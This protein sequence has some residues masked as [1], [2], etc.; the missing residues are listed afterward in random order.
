[1]RIRFENIRYLHMLCSDLS[2]VR[3]WEVER[4]RG[5]WILGG[6]TAVIIGT[7]EGLIIINLSCLFIT[8]MGTQNLF[9]SASSACIYKFM[10][11][12][13][14]TSPKA[15]FF[16]AVFV[17]FCTAAWLS[18]HF[19]TQAASY[20]MLHFNVYSHPSAVRRRVSTDVVMNCGSLLNLLAM[21][22]WTVTPTVWNIQKSNLGLSPTWCTKF[23]F[24]YIWYIY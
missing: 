4:A 6:S 5:I 17:T 2:I 23:L 21:F 7:A 18:F 16:F 11:M 9:K 19:G 14:V 15:T 20:G 8:C 13:P 1:M 24:I 22:D 12:P 3:N 10:S